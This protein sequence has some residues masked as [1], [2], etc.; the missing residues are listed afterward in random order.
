MFSGSAGYRR[1]WIPA[2]AGMTGKDIVRD[3]SLLVILAL[4]QNPSRTVV[5]DS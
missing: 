5:S 3:F 1:R 2:C 4:C